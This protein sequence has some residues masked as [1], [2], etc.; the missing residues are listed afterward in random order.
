MSRSISIAA[1]LTALWS[2][3]QVKAD[4]MT[5]IVIDGNFDD[6]KNVPSRY[7]PVDLPN[8]SVFDGNVPDCHDTD[9]SGAADIPVH[10]YNPHADIVEFKYTHDENFVYTYIRANAEIAKTLSGSKPGRYYII[11]TVDVDEDVT[12]GYMLNQGGYYPTSGGYD[13]N[14]E[15]EYYNGSFNQATFL[16]HGAFNDVTKELN[17]AANK[18]GTMLLAPATYNYYTEYIYWDSKPTADEAK[19]CLD[20]PYKLPGQDVMI[21]FSLDEAPGPFYSSSQA[22]AVGTEVE[23]RHSLKGFLKSSKDGLD[24]IRIGSTLK[25]SISLETSGEYSDPAGMWVSDTAAPFKYVLDPR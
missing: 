12:T 18:N 25:V 20:G 2:L 13:V 14:H 4:P 16:D 21:C 24:T 22:K 7:D 9:H 15:C 23:L 17:F 19:R 8:G 1:I 11:S 6:W 3:N 5:D 10:V